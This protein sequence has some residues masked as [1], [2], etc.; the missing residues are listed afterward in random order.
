M[1]HLK[2]SMQNYY[3]N[4][5]T[6][7]PPTFPTHSTNFGHSINMLK[8][9]P[10][11]KKILLVHI[12]QRAYSSKIFHWSAVGKGDVNGR[13]GRGEIIKHFVTEKSASAHSGVCAQKW[14]IDP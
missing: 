13:V 8:F 4:K 1:Y 3:Q 12:Y 6:D 9:D 11:Y 7:V 2:C 5:Y 14:D 10:V